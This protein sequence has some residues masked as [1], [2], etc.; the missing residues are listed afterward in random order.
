I[1]QALQ[2]QDKLEPLLRDVPERTAKLMEDLTRLGQDLARLLRET[3]HLRELALSLRQAQK[4]ID[5][6]SA[7]WPD[8][9]DSLKKTSELLKLSSAQLDQALSNRKEY[10]SALRQS[11]ELADTFAE[12]APLFTEEIHT[13]LAEQEEGLADLSKSLDHVG[14]TLPAYRKGAI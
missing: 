6:A 8:V 4:G 1:S 3:K 5:T 2:Q 7:R 12:A 13:Q 10:E 14:N 11:T 9:R